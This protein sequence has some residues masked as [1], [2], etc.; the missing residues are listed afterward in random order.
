MD[1]PIAILLC[2]FFLTLIV[3]GEIYFGLDK[4]RMRA[5]ACIQNMRENLDKWVEGT[6]ELAES[7]DTGRKAADDFRALAQDY[8]SYKRYKEI[9]KAVSLVNSL[10]AMAAPLED[11][12]FG[13]KAGKILAARADSADRVEP[14]RNE[15]NNCVRRLNSRL[16]KKIPAVVGKLFRISRMEKLNQL[17]DA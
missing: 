11:E 10:A 8:F 1:L 16:D 5:I 13:T 6:V 12:A 15:Y 7:S 9:M 4:Q 3:F 2:L 14:L 17:S